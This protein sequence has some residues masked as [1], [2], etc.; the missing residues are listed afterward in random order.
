MKGFIF[1]ISL[2]LFV[3]Q[4]ERLQFIKDQEC[5]FGLSSEFL[6]D[7][8]WSK[9]QDSGLQWSCLHWRLLRSDFFMFYFYAEVNMM[10]KCWLW[11]A[12]KRLI[13]YWST[14]SVFVLKFVFF[15]TGLTHS[16]RGSM[17]CWAPHSKPSQN[18]KTPH[19]IIHS[20]V[21][22]WI[23]NFHWQLH[24]NKSSKS[25]SPLSK[26]SVFSPG[27]ASDLTQTEPTVF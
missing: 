25:E 27:C 10:W 9:L 24:T 18:R 12:G 26:K 4:L 2:I 21:C 11:T 14:L 3:I 22:H 13:L 6:L 15:L 5:F 23:F 1:L 20:S 16:L 17:Q 7:L 19:W 8:S